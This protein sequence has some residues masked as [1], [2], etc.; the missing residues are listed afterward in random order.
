MVVSGFQKFCRVNLADIEFKQK[1]GFNQP[2]GLQMSGDLVDIFSRL[3]RKIT[4]ADIFRRA[5]DL[6]VVI[7]IKTGQNQ[8][9]KDKNKGDFF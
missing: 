6:A 7:N 2:G 8:K 3:N 4:R 1:N 5:I 9:Q